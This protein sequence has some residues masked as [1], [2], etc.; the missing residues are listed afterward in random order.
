MFI[1]PTQPVNDNVV[2]FLDIP[3]QP[4]AFAYLNM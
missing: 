4:R 2:K 1:H 3:H